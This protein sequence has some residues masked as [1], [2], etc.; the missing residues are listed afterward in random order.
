VLALAFIIHNSIR[1]YMNRPTTAG[2]TP[3]QVAETYYGAF[4]DLDHE[5]ME[6]CVFKNAGKSDID[7]VMNFFVTSRVREAYE[8]NGLSFLSAE[9]W[10]ELGG[11]ATTATVLGVTDLTLE[12]LDPDD[13]DGE[14]EFRASYTL[15]L[16]GS[17]APQPE[18]EE[19]NPFSARE[20]EPLEPWPVDCIDNLRLV[21]EKGNWRIVEMDRITGI[22]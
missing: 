14:T 11:G 7:M 8:M 18:G 10:L 13:S 4:G 12:I 3:Q 19:D 1:T 21:Q 17:Y 9:Q 15:W 5:K 6:A 22:E 16:P 2:L 20:P